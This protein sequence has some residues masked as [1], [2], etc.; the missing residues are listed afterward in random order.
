M[1]IIM[2][3]ESDEAEVIEEKDAWFY[4]DVDEIS[5]NDH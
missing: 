4:L 3:S 2:I 1:S 5:S